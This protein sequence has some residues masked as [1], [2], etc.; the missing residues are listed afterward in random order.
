MKDIYKWGIL[1]DDGEIIV[2]K[3]GFTMC[4]YNGIYHI[5][6][7]LK[8][9]IK[10]FLRFHNKY[11]PRYLTLIRLDNFYKDIEKRETIK[12]Y[13]EIFEYE[14][15]RLVKMNKFTGFMTMDYFYFQYKKIKN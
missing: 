2:H 9:I 8:R 14:N 15:P 6:N 12:I 1:K 10:W 5:R 13:I 4:S 11:P 7:I 3:R